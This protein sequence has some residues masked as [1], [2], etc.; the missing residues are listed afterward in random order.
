MAP[1]K[2]FA[3]RPGVW[4]ILFHTLFAG[5]RND[6]IPCDSSMLGYIEKMLAKTL[7]IFFPSG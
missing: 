5:V 1:G 6:Y 4:Q 7:D 2:T 3:P